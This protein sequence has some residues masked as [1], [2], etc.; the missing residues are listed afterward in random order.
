MAIRL[1]CLRQ[2]PPAVLEGLSG[3]DV[4]IIAD[5]AVEWAVERADEVRGL[6]NFAG[7]LTADMLDRLP[8][9]EMISHMGVGYDGVDVDA[10]LA[11]GITM[12]H[13]RDVL[14][15][16]VANF[17]F[18][19]LLAA[20][21]DYVRQDTHVRSGAWE[22]GQTPLTWSIEGK[23]VG[24]VG[25]GRIGR[26]LARKLTAFNVDVL[27]HGRRPQDVPYEYCADLVGMAR[28]CRALVLL[29]PGGA[30][31]DGLITAEVLAALGPEGGLVNA[32]R[33][34]VVDQ[35]ALIAALQDGS[36]GWAALDVFADEPHVPEVLRAMP[37]VLLSP[38][39]ASATVETRGA[40]FDL[41]VRNL[42]AF[43][44]TG[45]AVTPIP[46]CS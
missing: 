17:A 44:E 37:N 41:V 5:P 24:I 12:S 8:G 45:A 15:A 11:R 26:N 40:M 27:Y 39:A 4:E 22:S 20:S 6:V 46:E 2:P 42:R 21:R 28:R 29:L 30:E 19:M 35:E 43:F 13:T 31:T 32:A 36:L 18:L 16:D 1:V 23:T 14:D 33:G 3:Y 38:H 7:A 34:S 9:L 10:V 25:L